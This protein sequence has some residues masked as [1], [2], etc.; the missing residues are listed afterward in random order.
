MEGGAWNSACK[1]MLITDP[2][3]WDPLKTLSECF[4]LFGPTVTLQNDFI[5]LA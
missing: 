1:K 4:A 3:N 2:E 5:A